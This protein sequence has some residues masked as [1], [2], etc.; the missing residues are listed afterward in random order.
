M[1]TRIAPNLPSP[2]KIRQHP[3]DDWVESGSR[4]GKPNE[5]Q[6]RAKETPSFEVQPGAL[7]QIKIP[8]PP[9]L[10]E[11]VRRFLEESK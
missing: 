3:F 2:S 4:L 5:Y 10:A 6:R 7:N 1:I 11:N 8:I 9:K